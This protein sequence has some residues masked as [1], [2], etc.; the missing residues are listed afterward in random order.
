[1]VPY[2]SLPLVLVTMSSME[3]AILAVSSQVIWWMQSEA[4]ASGTFRPTLVNA[5][6]VALLYMPALW[7]VLRRPN[8]GEL[9]LFLE[10]FFHRPSAAIETA[11]V[12][13][14]DSASSD[15]SVAP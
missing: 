9:P 7:M 3:S 11:D 4:A 10:R 12:L 15:T 1:M 14:R 2:D 6:Y 8:E 13:E 5:W